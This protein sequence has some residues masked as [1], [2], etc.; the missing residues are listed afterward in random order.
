MID[1][2]AFIS[3]ITGGLLAAP[4]A[5]EAQ[6]VGKVSRIGVFTGAAPSPAWDGLWQG[7]HELGWVEGKN[8]VI[9]RRYAEGKFDRL[10]DIAAEL[11]NLKVDVIVAVTNRAAFP[12]RQATSTIPIVA[13]AMHEAVGV[14]LV[15][16]L[17]RPA[18]NVTGVESQAP[19]LDVK[20]LELLRGLSPKVSRLAVLYNPGDPAMQFHRRHTESAAQMFGMTVRASEVRIPQDFDSV[21]AAMMKERPDAL[22]TFT[23]TFMFTHRRLIAEFALNNRLPTVFEYKEFV[24]LGGLVSY[25]PNLKS[26]YHRAAFFID[27]ILKGARPADLP[28]EQPTK[29]ELVVN[30]KTARA[31]NLT[32]PPSLLARADQVIE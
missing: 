30:V 17:A 1:R 7:L 9:E 28:V 10:P 29:L 14:G 20:R 5:A 31:L 23:D 27:K 21:F 16:S 12:A 19:E 25:G 3:V 32:V 15:A 18:G 11:V 24:E 8:L 22:L 26:L 2:R 13:I 6:Q 4:L